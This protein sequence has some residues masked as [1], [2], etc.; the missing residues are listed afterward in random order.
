[1]N[2]DRRN[3]QSVISSNLKPSKARAYILN[4]V[5]KFFN[6]FVVFRLDLKKKNFLK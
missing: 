1:M 5:E 3:L 2:Y 4:F 6:Y